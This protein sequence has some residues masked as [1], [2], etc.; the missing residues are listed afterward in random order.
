MSSVVAKLDPKFRLEVAKTL[1]GK[2]FYKCFQCG[3]CTSSCPVADAMDVKP[4]QVVKM[5]LLGMREE[6][7]KSDAIWVCSTC[8]TCDERCPQGVKPREIMEALKRTIIRERGHAVRS[9]D[10]YIYYMTFMENL[11]NHGR[12]HEIGF[13]TKFKLKTTRVLGTLSYVPFGLELLWKGKIAFR[14]HIIG[15]L[16]ELKEAFERA[17]EAEGLG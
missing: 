6:V 17:E 15:Q 1:G 7:I 9:K 14:P 12:V 11:K 4:Y 10:S 13:F 2:N 3:V 8:F 5:V 16:R